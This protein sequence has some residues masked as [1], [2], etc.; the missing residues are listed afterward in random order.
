MAF[1]PAAVTANP[2]TAL[3]VGGLA[4]GS[5]SSLFS[6]A[7]MA[8]TEIESARQQF[9]ANEL[10]RAR[11]AQTAERDRKI[12]LARRIALISAAGGF[13][14]AADLVGE[15]SL[16]HTLGLERSMTDLSFQGG[17]LRTRI[18]NIRGGLP[19]SNLAVMSD[20]ALKGAQILRSG[21][22]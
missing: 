20:T 14:D 4:V 15:V 11:L 3:A 1:L 9:R 6:N 19:F 8:Q 13:Q 5:V 2:W 7:L 18:S 16:Q 17:V 12:D 21:L 10:Q 22:L